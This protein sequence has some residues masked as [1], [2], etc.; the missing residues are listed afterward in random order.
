MRIS[1]WSSDVCSS[2][3]RPRPP[4]LRGY[5]RQYRRGRRRRHGRAGGRQH[6]AVERRPCEGG[7]DGFTF[8]YPV[9]PPAASTASVT[10]S[11]AGEAMV[12]TWTGFSMPTSTGPITAP[13]LRSPRSFPDR[14]AD[15]SPAMTTWKS[16]EAVKGVASSVEHG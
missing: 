15:F 11:D 6:R 3:H 2:D 7:G 10:R 8:R 14:F 16:V 5:L 4:L 13:S 9:I 1:D 12:A